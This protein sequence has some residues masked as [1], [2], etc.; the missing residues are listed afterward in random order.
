MSRYHPVINFVVTRIK[1]SSYYTV[2]DFFYEIDDVT[3]EALYGFLS[4][5]DQ[6]VKTYANPLDSYN[7]LNFYL[8]ATLLYYGEGET[9]VSEKDLESIVDALATLILLERTIRKQENKSKYEVIR[10]D[11][12]LGDKNKII[13]KKKSGV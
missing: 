9:K 4:N 2:G 8:L 6:D 11:Y 13:A 3:L 12:S 7:V 1:S 5:L 10:R